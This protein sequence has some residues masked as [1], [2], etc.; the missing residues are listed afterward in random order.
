MSEQ[1]SPGEGTVTNGSTGPTKATRSLRW[2][3]ERL[4]V[5]HGGRKLLDK[6]FPDHW[7]FM[8]GEIALYS[9]IVLVIT[10][11]FLT[12]YFIPSAR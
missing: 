10:G 8:L 1:A 4:G 6:I 3:D 7:S 9:F 12:L 11:T 5:A 2:L